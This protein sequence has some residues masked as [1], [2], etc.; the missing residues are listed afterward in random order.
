MFDS[1]LGTDSD[2]ITD[3]AAGDLIV[4]DRNVFAALSGGTALTAVEFSSAAGLSAATTAQQRILHDSTTGALRYDSDGTGGPVAVQFATLNVGA[5]VSAATF[6]L[7][8]PVPPPPPPPP[9]PAIHGTICAH[10]PPGTPG[11]H[12]INGPD[13]KVQHQ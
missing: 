11:H 7:T 10:N 4:L 3:L 5:P 1:V 9:V 13:G 12:T 2:T 8:G 6:A